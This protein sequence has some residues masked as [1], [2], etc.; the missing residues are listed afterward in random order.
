MGK[1]ARVALATAIFLV[2]WGLTTHGKH[3]V[4]GDEPHY[5]MVAQSL[6]SDGDLDL[7]NNYRDDQGRLFGAAGLQPELHARPALD[8]RLL[9]VHDIGLPILLLP[10]YAAARGLASVAPPATLARFRMTPGLFAYSL[11]SLVIAALFTLSAVVTATALG[12]Q[13]VSNRASMVAVLAVWLTAPLLSNSFLVFPEAV[14]LAV[15]AWTVY[16][17]GGVRNSRWRGSDWLLVAALGALPWV[18]RKYALYACAL[19]AVMVWKR[20]G[21]PKQRSRLAGVVALY[22]IPQAALAW[23][24]YR[25]WGN[26]AGPIALDRLPFSR[27]AVAHGLLGTFFD[28]ENGLLWWAPAYAVLPAV[29]WVRGKEGLPWLAPV[30]ALIVPGAAH[31]Q[32]WGGFS[33]AARFLVPLAPV[34]CVV[35]VPALVRRRWVR[36]TAVGLLVPQLLIAAY[37]WQRPRLLWP[38][39][40]GHNRILERLAPWL[41]AWTPSLRTMTEHAWSRA[42]ELLAGV[43]VLNLLLVLAAQRDLAPPAEAPVS[44]T[45][46]R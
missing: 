5:L 38:V 42:F 4:S 9:P 20:R 23:W 29:W 46:R 44:P 7:R 31:D 12:Q 34:V 6:L 17:C 43:V 13:G 11:V 1:R 8:G 25:H 32:W 22:A 40:D 33:P 14:A 30:I 39:G 2:I 45:N 41:N 35:S 19:L 21:N 16:A 27:D 24:T 26:L 36:A 10:A 37:G 3:S 18:H 15:T 28:R